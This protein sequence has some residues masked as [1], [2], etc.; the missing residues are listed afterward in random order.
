MADTPATD[1]AEKRRRRQGAKALNPAAAPTPADAPEPAARRNGWPVPNPFSVLFFVF[2]VSYLV[3]KIKKEYAEDDIFRTTQSTSAEAAPSA[4]VTTPGAPI[5]TDRIVAIGDLHG[6][7][8]N[9][10]SVFQMAGLADTDGNWVGNKSI[11]VQTG[12]IVDR[13]P[14]T[15]KLYVF[16]RRLTKQAAEAGGRV[17]PLLGNHEVMNMMEDFR[18]VANEDVESFGG[19]P[20][21][22]EA[23]SKDG[24]LG[25]YLRTWDITAIVNGTVFL[26]GG[27][28]PTWAA[29]GI[30][31]LNKAARTALT[32]RTPHELWGV[33]LFQGDGPLWY[34]GYANDDEKVVCD[35]L[36]T[37]LGMVNATRMVIGHTPQLTG[38]I[39]S[40]CNNKVHVVDV[41]ISSVYGGNKAALEISGNRVVAIYPGKRVL[42]TDEE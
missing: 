41:G 10:L 28:H 40:R 6:D 26:H 18:Y 20:Q 24:W 27:L 35:T 5:L 34:R 19:M 37:A 22:K 38:E 4:A 13:G 31:A 32:T 2:L 42:I 15:M 14:D 12:D 25:R 29:Q 3:W 36:D 9:A 33:K 16:I 8:P 7:Y 23:W 21:R 11:L 39:L 30:D 17:V 1:R